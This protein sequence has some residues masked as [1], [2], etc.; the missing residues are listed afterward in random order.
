MG[1]ATDDAA[2]AR[3]GQERRHQ[4][5]TRRRALA[6]LLVGGAYVAGALLVA[7]LAEAQPGL[8]A[9][10]AVALV[11]MF[12]MS[13][14]VRIDI[15]VIFT[16]PTQLAFV[17]MLLLL[18]TSTVPLLVLLGWTLGRLPSVLPPERIHPDR[19]L[20]I[21][22]DCWFAMGPVLVL[23]AF[24]A[25]TPRWHHWPVYLLALIAQFTVEGVTNYLRQLLGEDTPPRLILRELGLVWAIDSFLSP[26]ALLA[27]FASEGF[28]YAFLLLVPLA[29]LLSV[30]ARERSRS[31]DRALALADAAR[32]RE[33]LIAG[34]SHELVTPLGVLVGLTGR[35]TA[36]RELT[37]ERR[38]EIDTVMRREVIALRQ[39][40][41]QFVDYTRLKTEREI[42]LRPEAVPLTPIAEEIA[43]ALDGS[44]AV[45]V[46]V[47]GTLPPARVDPDRAHQMI[48][49]IAMEAL[50]G[51]DTAI[52]SLRAAG[53]AVTVTATSAHELRE[54]PFAEGGEGS[55][56]GL[57]LY[58]TRELA[59]M[60]GGELN[61]E[62]TPDGGARYV[63]ALPRAS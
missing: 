8:D 43:R 15:G 17:C 34:A 26:I 46:E 35:L 39:I 55:N 62:P 59:R 42:Q 28:R 11:V 16:T 54:R 2:R 33:G 29:G 49:A 7:L 1:E 52:L 60:H 31:L 38:A 57:G 10:V 30:Y 21:P 23:L 22:S 19:L 32:D 40:V 41:R 63:L 61:A 13:M 27:V 53:D 56:G 5:L 6:E 14:R 44:G 18:P 12:A 47:P 25:Q 45:T 20:L 24:D 9:G 3:R 4:P 37:P 51:A 50:E 58:V 48:T 36:G